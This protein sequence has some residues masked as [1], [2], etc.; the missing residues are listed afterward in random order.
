MNDIV[1]VNGRAL[2]VLIANAAERG[3]DAAELER[4]LFAREEHASTIA[5]AEAWLRRS[6]VEM[7]GY[8]VAG[9]A[10]DDGGVIVR[11][12]V[13]VPSDVKQGAGV[14]A[15]LRMWADAD[16]PGAVALR[17]NASSQE[18]IE[19]FCPVI[20]PERHSQDE[21]CEVCP[22]YGDGEKLC[23]VYDLVAQYKFHAAARSMPELSV[24]DLGDFEI[25]S[26]E[27]YMHANMRPLLDPA[28]LDARERVA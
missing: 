21:D 19:A 9:Y 27:I 22:E 28:T 23:Q 11:R 26:D 7:E 18:A 15:E 24:F 5:D 10:V 8:G 16:N 4:K 25:E 2:R 13:F 3:E 17:L 14:F 6:A 12:E 1:K 20:E